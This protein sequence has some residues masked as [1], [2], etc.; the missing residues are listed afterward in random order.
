MNQAS[1]TSLPTLER[2]LRLMRELIGSVKRAQTAVVRSELAALEAEIV[3]Q[4]QLCVAL[5]EGEGGEGDE[6]SLS[7]PQ[8]PQKCDENLSSS[9][10]ERWRTLSSELADA[11]AEASVVNRAYG[12][13]LRR[14]RRTVE[15]FARVVACSAATYPLPR[16]ACAEG[17]LAGKEIHV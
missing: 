5:R 17:D 9:A 16:A 4:Q 8:F 12:A 1:F 14:A 11:E 10:G 2:R 3:K 13:L 7:G 15:I 6:V